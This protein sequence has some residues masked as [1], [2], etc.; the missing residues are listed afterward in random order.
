M[1]GS[2]WTQEADTPFRFG[3]KSYLA[4]A[5]LTLIPIQKKLID[6]GLM[7]A[8]DVKW[9]N[10]YH[11]WGRFLPFHSQGYVYDKVRQGVTSK[12]SKAKH[13]PIAGSEQFHASL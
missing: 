8:L 10:D 2:P 9:L 4:F 13:G 11:K 1:Y 7:S 6:F 5:Y 12:A 3:G